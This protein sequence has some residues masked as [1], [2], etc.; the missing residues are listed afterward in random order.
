MRSVFSKC[1]EAM[2]EGR[3]FENLSWRL[4]NRET[5]CCG[6]SP[7]TTSPGTPRR[8]H[9]S[10]KHDSDDVP[11]LSASVKSAASDKHDAVAS[12]FEP[13]SDAVDIERPVFVRTDSYE[14][15]SRGRERH[16]TS[17]HLE[18]MFTNIKE[19][20]EL[21]QLPLSSVAR[22]AMMHAPSDR[23]T[24][25]PS[26]PALTVVRSPRPES[27]ADAASHIPTRSASPA[28]ISTSSSP[29]SALKRT[30]APSDPVRTR[31]APKRRNNVFMLGG[32]SGEDESSLDEHMHPPLS[33]RGSLSDGSRHSLTVKK[34]TSFKEEVITRT[35]DEGPPGDEEAITDDD[36]MDED[37]D[38]D[39]EDVVS[40]SAIEDDDSSDWDSI[41]ESG[42]SSVDERPMFQR[43]D[44]KPNLTSR[45]S[46]LTNLL[47]QSQREAAFADEA[48]RTTPAMRRSRTSSPNGPSV[49]GSPEEAPLEMRRTDV[50]RSK[51]I[52]MTVPQPHPP[53]LSPRTTRRNMLQTELTESL[54]KHLLWER[55]QKNTT[56]TAAL[57]RRHTAHDVSNLHE[58]PTER[59]G[60]GSRDTSKNNSWNHYFDLGLGE[61]HQKGW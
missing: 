25:P 57:K 7:R 55:Q 4:W 51:P 34:Q 45:R 38:D 11:E 12:P 27:P 18:R 46:L 21:E 47:H 19:T 20:K 54:R 24:R 14:S 59:R 5:F 36:D 58:Y 48:A 50:P 40:E 32:S 3:R 26:P 10:S 8:R 53:T 28:H 39:D 1:A 44:S 17:F 49:V 2:E 29:R 61:Y 16:M 52:V 31:E 60:D 42:R 33:S 41:S 43:V 23:T 9:T 37:D 22:P 56:A 35:I 6:S 30:H 13:R 15:R